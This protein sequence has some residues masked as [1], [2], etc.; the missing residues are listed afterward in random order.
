MLNALLV[1]PPQYCVVADRDTAELAR[2]QAEELL[3]IQDKRVEELTAQ[4]EALKQETAQATAG[5]MKA[6][7]DTAETGE[8]HKQIDGLKTEISTL[9]GELAAAEARAKKA[10]S[11]QAASEAAAAAESE[12]E[13]EVRL[14]EQITQLS[15]EVATEVTRARR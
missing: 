12:S 14:R 7:S 6:S 11:L 2:T 5:Q 1:P 8:L 15:S 10:E 3:S 9:K 4:V 13:V